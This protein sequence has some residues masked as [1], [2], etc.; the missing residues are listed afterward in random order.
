VERRL[1]GIHEPGG[2]AEAV[3][4]P[5]RLLHK[6]PGSLPPASA[7]LAEPKSSDAFSAVG[8]SVLLMVSPW[9]RCGVWWAQ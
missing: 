9:V 2:I 1:F 6:L 4:V 8:L 7:A 3:A 5:S